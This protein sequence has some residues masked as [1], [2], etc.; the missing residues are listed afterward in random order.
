[1]ITLFK[2]LTSLSNPTFVGVDDAL[3]RIR[4]GESREMVEAVRSENDKS[5]R[6][7]IKQKLPAVC[8]SGKFKKRYMSHLE[9][10][11]GF[12]ILDFDDYS[13][14]K[15]KTRKHE[16]KKDPYIYAAWVSPSGLGVKA[17]VK[18]P[19]CS[20]EQHRLYFKAIRNHFNDEPDT[21]GSDVSRVCFESYDPELYVNKLSQTF[22]HLPDEDEFDKPYAGDPFEFMQ[23][24]P[25]L[26]VVDPDQIYERVIQWLSNKGHEFSEGGRNEY[27]LR[28]A[29]ALN[30]FGASREEAEDICVDNFSESGFGELEIKSTVRSAYRD[31]AR[32]ATQYFEDFE[33]I[34]AIR[35]RLSNG[36]SPETI[37]LDLMFTHNL[38][39]A[40]AEE[41]CRDEAKEMASDVFWKVTKIKKAVKIEFL[42]KR[43]IRFLKKAGFY[44]YK[45]GRGYVTYI[46]VE[47]N[48]VDEIE[49]DA[50]KKYV[51]DWVLTRPAEMFDIAS[52]DDV[53]EFLAKGIKTY[54]SKELLELMPVYNLQLNKDT[55]DKAFFYFRNGVV[56]INPDEIRLRDYDVLTGMVWKNQIRDRDF[57]LKRDYGHNDYSRLIKLASDCPK[58]LES[59]V[60]YLLHRY[61]DVTNSRAVILNDK[62]ISDHPEGGSGKGLIMA[63]IGKIRNMVIFDGKTYTT[64]KN[65]VHQR[66]EFDTDNIFI[67]DVDKNFNFEAL[68]SLITEGV[69]VEKKHKGEVMIPFA[70]SPKTSIA[71]NYYIR[72]FGMSNDRRKFEV[73]M[74]NYFGQKTPLDQFGK[75]LF[76]DWDDVEWNDFDNSMAAYCQAYMR[77]GFQEAQSDSLRLKKVIANSSPEF[78]E[79]VR[80]AV[81]EGVKYNRA[82]LLGAFKMFIEDTPVRFFPTMRTFMSHLKSWADYKEYTL[83]ESRSGN[84]FYVTLIDPL[85]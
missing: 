23:R 72:G 61:K 37:A 19:A 67:D 5:K 7:E 56:V 58:A 42:S 13:A 32:H 41:L 73:E 80:L 44:R 9:E 52:R 54:F 45:P 66:I 62:V 82:D 27:V 57:I 50:I 11:S 1:M 8:F 6:D 63:G 14:D 69:P 68:F 53:Y 77:D 76:E 51:F 31:K 59:A 43:F 70:D 4:N 36:E 12:L 17:L 25:R 49:I 24:P 78:V 34:R 18:I 21:S 30:R 39:Q 48:V 29:G 35:R 47:N 81:D 2:N 83:E 60:G 15:A 26:A 75:R 79:W 20:A 16:L 55:K 64:K 65:F 38:P 71:T 84:D 46:K 74:N 3:A 22:T 33:E 28:V 40:D 10:H 85:A